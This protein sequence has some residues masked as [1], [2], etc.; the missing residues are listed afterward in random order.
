MNFFITFTREEIVVE[1]W[2]SFS[3]L[4]K[5]KELYLVN[6]SANDEQEVETR[7]LIK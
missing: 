6:D 2:E 7:S 4:Q 1:I 3:A 5:K